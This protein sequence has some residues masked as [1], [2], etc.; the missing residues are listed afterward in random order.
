M[1]NGFWELL[2]RKDNISRDLLRG[3]LERFVKSEFVGRVMYKFGGSI[4]G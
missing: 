3:L 4:G 1:V 2:L